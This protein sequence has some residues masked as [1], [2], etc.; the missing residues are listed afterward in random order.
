[1]SDNPQGRVT[2]P[3]RYE[4]GINT[5][6]IRISPI[7]TALSCYQHAVRRPRDKAKVEN[8]VGIVERYRTLEDYATGVSSRSTS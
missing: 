2:K 5:H 7:I 8:A 3:S 4:P 1:M 6:A